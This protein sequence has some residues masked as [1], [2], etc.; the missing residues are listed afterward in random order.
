MIKSEEEEENKR[1]VCDVKVFWILIMM[2]I[3][4]IV[5]F[6]VFLF[7]VLIFQLNLFD[8]FKVVGFI[9]LF[10]QKFESFGFDFL[11]QYR[12]GLIFNEIRLFLIVLLL[13]FDFE[14]VIFVLD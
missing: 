6:F 9:S 3:N 2:S 13:D 14:W 10:V 4:Q 11:V 7:F 8:R 5:G 1:D 12:K